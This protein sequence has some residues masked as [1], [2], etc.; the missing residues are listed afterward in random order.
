[1]M[2][3]DGVVRMGSISALARR[4]NV[5]D[6][7]ARSALKFLEGPDPDA[8]DQEDLGVRLER[9]TGG[10]LVIKGEQYR[11]MKT[12]QDIREQNRL[13]QAKRRARLRENQ[14]EFNGCDERDKRD[15]HA[16]SRD[17]TKSHT[18]EQIR[19]DSKNTPPPEKG[20]ESNFFGK[21]G[22]VGPRVTPDF[23]EIPSLEEVLAWND[24]RL[25]ADKEWLETAYHEAVSVGWLDYK[26]RRI[27]AW[28][29]YF[30]GI[31][32]AKRNRLNER[33]QNTGV[34]NKGKQEEGTGKRG[35]ASTAYA[36]RQ[37][38]DGVKIEIGGIRG[39]RDRL[40]S[41]PLASE[42]ERKIRSDYTE[43]LKELKQKENDI[44][45]RLADLEVPE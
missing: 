1:M 42:E 28:K 8:T 44:Q 9:I 7:G 41:G 23:A 12:R 4:A 17:V 26:Q 14:M 15:S 21:Q 25:S 10:W 35:A 34:G 11:N 38:L 32:R 29:S 36:L 37:K 27:V 31:W 43:Q 6:S 45:R 18:S 5:S 39:K 40:T 33:G 30:T 24:G 16:E 20:D 13:R 3:E 19:T 2:D 22:D